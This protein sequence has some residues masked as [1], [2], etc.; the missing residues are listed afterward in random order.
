MFNTIRCN[1]WILRILALLHSLIDRPSFAWKYLQ[2]GKCW[3]IWKA[4][5][6]RTEVISVENKVWLWWR[7]QPNESFYRME[8][9][10]INS[11]SSSVWEHF[12]ISST[13]VPAGDESKEFRPQLFVLDESMLLSR[14]EIQFEINVDWWMHSIRPT[15]LEW[16]NSRRCERTKPRYV[17]PEHSLAFV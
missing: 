10:S 9:F 5:M 3:L 14:L 17:F 8:W 1:E 7:F 2:I 12:W 4:T 11:N 16:Q 13:R 6:Y 15:S